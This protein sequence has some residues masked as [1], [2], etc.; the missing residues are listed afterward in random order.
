MMLGI[1][2]AMPSGTERTLA[3]AKTSRLSIALICGEFSSGRL[4]GDNV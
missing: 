2:W 4:I 3:N 1:A